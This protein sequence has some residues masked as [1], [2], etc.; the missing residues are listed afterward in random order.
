MKR[1]REKASPERLCA[2]RERQR[3]LSKET[4]REPRQG[5]SRS[6]E[7]KN[8]SPL[9]LR[10]S[11]D[12]RSTGMELGHV[13]AKSPG[14]GHPSACWPDAAA[15]RSGGIKGTAAMRRAVDKPYT[16]TSGSGYH[17]VGG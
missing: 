6:E 16:R 1:E 14:T 3:S 5:K 2:N 13:P 7:E 12:P 10:S 9:R 4:S 17:V 15:L 8:R 11:I